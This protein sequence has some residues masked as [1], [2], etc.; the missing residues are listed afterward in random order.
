MILLES[1]IQDLRSFDAKY[2]LARQLAVYGYRAVI[3]DATAPETLPGAMKYEA[4]PYLANIS[5]INIEHMLLIGAE[6][7][8]DDTLAGLRDHRFAPLTR[9]SA[10]GRFGDTQS[11]ISA[12]AKLA[13]VLGFEPEV[14]DLTNLQPN[15]M[16]QP[17]LAPLLASKA[18][19]QKRDQRQTQ[20]FLILPK[21]VLEDESILPYLTVL[22][23][24]SGVECRVITAGI[25]KDQIKTSPSASTRVFGFSELFPAT[26]A[27]MADIAVFYGPNIPGERMASLA[28]D[29]MRQGGMVIDSTE[30]GALLETGAP[31]VRGPTDIRSLAMFLQG[32]ILVNRK[33]IGAEAAEHPWIRENSLERLLEAISFKKPKKQKIRKPREP[34][35]IFFP[36]NGVGLGHAQRCA[37]VARQMKTSKNVAFTAFPSCVPMLQSYGFDCLPLVQKSEFHSSNGSND[38]LNYLRLGHTLD[39]GD[40]LVFDGGYVFDSVYRTILE[41]Q[42]SAIWIRRGLFQ[43]GQTGRTPLERESVF[44]KVIVP[45]EVFEELNTNYTYSDHVYHVGP[46]VQQNELKTKDRNKLRARIK[47]L[48]KSPFKKLV[49]TLLGGGEAADRTAQMQSLC[50]QF[51]A[52]PDC[53]HLIV[54][55]PNAKISSSLMGWPNSHIVR[56]MRAAELSQAADFIVSATGYNSFNEAMY[57]AVPAIFIPQM[58]PYT[59]DQERR[60]RA[61]TERDLSVMVLSNEL[62]LLQREVSAFLEGDKANAIRKN[63]KALR[64]PETGTKAA[65][66]LIEA[67]PSK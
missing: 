28:L 49:V 52:H 29:L 20:I 45:A 63:L 48:F 51:A 4:I 37:L 16:L 54:V 32:S 53:L 60:A 2:Q 33:A 44:E 41:K 39:L 7:I 23:Q 61:A 38:L 31:V 43:P 18:K 64:L 56:S 12:Q 27:S 17:S 40:R 66:K 50:S 21:E 35:T 10:I 6:A 30:T 62:L 3:D 26:F 47:T 11:S 24:M 65:A 46:I 67:G 25:G 22:D 8:S 19:E 5:D 59:D 57:H 36:T 9:A 55:W 13:Y 42:L 14:H 15:P 34:R 1:G 58:A